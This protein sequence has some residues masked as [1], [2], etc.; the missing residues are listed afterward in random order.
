MKKTK[1]QNLFDI[2]SLQQGYFTAKEAVQAGFSYRMHTHY[3][4]NG[5]WLEI[6]RGIFRLAQFPNSPDED[7]VR[8]SLWSRDRKGKTQAVISHDSA[9]SIHELSDIMPSK[10]HFTVPPGFRKK[11]P[12]GCCIHRGR[13]SD[14]EKEQRE[15]FFVT[16]PLRTIIDSAESGFSI[17]YLEQAVRQA[18][19]RGMLQIID[20]VSAEMSEKAK[21]KIILVFKNMKAGREKAR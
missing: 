5:E 17:D 6:D 10:I 20:I 18:C 2:A 3:K 1:K 13:I 4:H 14:A 16:N 21:E 19:D 8:W 11:A 9:L 12:K 7:Y 15:G